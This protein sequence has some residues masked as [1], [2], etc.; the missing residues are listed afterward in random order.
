MVDPR[1]S[2]VHNHR[3]PA[4]PQSHDVEQLLRATFEEYA[5]RRA[6]YYDDPALLDKLLD[7]NLLLFAFRGVRTSTAFVDQA[8]PAH[9]ASSEETMMGNAWQ[10]AIST[11][12][13]HVVGGGD[14]RMERDGYLWIIQLK[15]SPKQNSAAKAQDLRLL[16]DKVLNERDHHPGRRGVK[17]MLAFLTGPS[18][19]RWVT[20][21][22]RSRAN[23]DI[24]G[25]GYQVMA[26]RAFL[27]WVGAEHDPAALVNHLAVSAARV[28]AARGRTIDRLKSELGDRLRQHGLPDTIESLMR[29]QE[30]P[31]RG[32]IRDAKRQ[33]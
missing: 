3:V 4:R 11:I 22:E 19:D 27:E 16:R 13:P 33:T 15:M 17:P 20:H 8:L 21:R 28:A 1:P 23:A 26:G 14:L 18:Q 30:L 5:A 31:S 29:L 32:R 10:S 6:A 7:K 9:E 2:T 24:H 25:F 12:S